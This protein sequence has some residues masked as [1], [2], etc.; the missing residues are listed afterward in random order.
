VT[1][2]A[3]E[4][5]SEPASDRVS[6][7]AF[8]GPLEA[9]LRH[10]FLTLL[11]LLL[12]AG[13]A[14]YFGSERNPVYTAEAR[15]SVGRADVPAYTLQN[16]VI[17]NST[18]A[19]G[20]ARAVDAPAVAQR[21]ARDAGIGPVD[22]RKRLSAS[23]IPGSTLIRV[24]AEGPS[25]VDAVR[26]ANAGSDSL[27]RYVTRLNAEQEPTNVLT[28]FRRARA[29]IDR[30]EARLAKLN[31]RP[32]R[33]RD[34]IRQAQLDLDVATLRASTLNDQYRGAQANTVDNL[35]QIIAPADSAKSDDSSY[36]QRL[37]I[38][39]VAAGLLIGMALAL[40]RSNAGLIG[41]RRR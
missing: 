23:P 20:Y 2:P 24:E 41:R 10:P 31:R 37:I 29:R 36:L 11:P 34:A 28:A 27:V 35:L 33:N 15:I 14:V 3:P 38:L 7:P 12:C 13:A 8:V 19:A 22:A 40:L 17:G 1:G 39:A 5:V 26:L 16:V 21:A 9:M 4:R 32:G 30:L 6:E 18:L 25:E